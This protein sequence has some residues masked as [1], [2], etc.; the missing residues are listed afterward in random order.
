[1]HVH[2]HH[3][4]IVAIGNAVSLLPINLLWNKSGRQI[5]VALLSERFIAMK[6]RLFQ[7]LRQ[8]DD[9]VSVGG[10]RREGA[11]TPSRRS[12]ASSLRKSYSLL[13]LVPAI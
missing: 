13:C 10:R 8:G 1:M 5:L 2:H 12:L 3:C 11:I 9:D 4:R 7:K 6:D